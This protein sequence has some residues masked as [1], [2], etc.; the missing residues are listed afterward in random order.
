M[1]PC[2]TPRCK[3]C[4]ILKVTDE[5]SSHT[6]GHLFQ[7]KF[8]ASGKS[9]NIV[10]L[11]TCR[12]CGLQYVG[13]TS[14]PL[15]ARIN[16]HRSDIMHRRTDVSLVAEHFNRGAHSVADMMVILIELFS[17]RDLCVRKVKEGR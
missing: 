8:H 14:Q 5:F 13:E 3:T 16:G 9:S 15:H 10:Y 11:I 12:R 4:P 2:G 7:V 1:Y 17:S 6:T